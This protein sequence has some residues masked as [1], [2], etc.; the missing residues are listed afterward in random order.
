MLATLPMRTPARRSPPAALAMAAEPGFLAE[1]D[2]TLGL[3]RTTG[4]RVSLY[5]LPLPGPDAD[6]RLAEARLALDPIAISGRLADGRLAVLYAGPRPRGGDHTVWSALHQRLRGISGDPFARAVRPA[7]AAHA[8]AAALRGVSD[9]IR[10][11][12]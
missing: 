11:L 12:G 5:A 10:L 8:Q 4:V 1:A 6:R 3:L 9:L 7:A 2:R